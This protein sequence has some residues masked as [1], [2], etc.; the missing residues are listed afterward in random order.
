VPLEGDQQAR[1]VRLRATARERAG[2]VRQAE[3]IAQERDHVALDRHGRGSVGGDGELWIEGCDERVG[4]HPGER[5]RRVEQAEVARVRGVDDAVVEQGAGRL[6]QLLQRDG[7]AEVESA[8]PFLEGLVRGR[9]RHG[10]V[11]DPVQ[12]ALDQ[13]GQLGVGPP[14]LIGAREQRAPLGYPRPRRP[15]GHGIS[16]AASE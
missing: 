5:G 15:C 11:A 3:A 14:P 2:G 4:E 10:E 1:E 16:Y 8:Q 12:V 7:R 13:L 6:H 9:R